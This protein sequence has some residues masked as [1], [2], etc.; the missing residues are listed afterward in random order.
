MD[1][2]GAEGC[3]GGG[4]GTAGRGGKGAG[5][6]GNGFGAAPA[7]GVGLLSSA[8]R[9]SRVIPVFDLSSAMGKVVRV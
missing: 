4:G 1:G 6:A 7:D 9:S 2:L 5:A 3:K 8:T